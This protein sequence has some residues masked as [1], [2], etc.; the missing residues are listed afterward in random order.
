MTTLHVQRV[1]DPPEG[2]GF[3][4]L[5]DRLWPRG[6]SKEAAAVDLWA[7]ELCPSD[8]LRRWYHDDP[9]ARFEDFS[10]RYRAELD[11]DDTSGVVDEL[12][13]QDDVVLLTAVKEPGHSHVTVLS[14]WLAGQG[15]TADEAFRRG[16]ST[17]SRPASRLAA[18]VER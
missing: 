7:K 12:R 17:S 6:V 13:R 10:E 18:I 4:V 15:F 11:A 2:E 9:D 5:V 3:R 14:D 8:E 16:S 1:Y